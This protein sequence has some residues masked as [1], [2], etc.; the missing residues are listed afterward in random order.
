MSALGYRWR[1]PVCPCLVTTTSRRIISWRRRYINWCVNGMLPSGSR[2]CSCR[3]CRR[4]HRRPSTICNHIRYIRTRRTTT[5]LQSSSG[6]VIPTSTNHHH[7]YIPSGYLLRWTKVHAIIFFW[8]DCRI[9]A[10]PNFERNASL[11]NLKLLTIFVEASSIA[12]NEANKRWN[13]QNKYAKWEQAKDI[14]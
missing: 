7:R 14:C 12:R 4:R 3:R 6:T 9:L 8:D 10:M 1:R 2:A 5:S 11:V 13:I